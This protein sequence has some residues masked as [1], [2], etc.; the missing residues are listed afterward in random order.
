MTTH[1]V[2]RV[3][4]LGEHKQRLVENVG[5]ESWVY[6][7]IPVKGKVEHNG[8]KLDVY[9]FEWAKIPPHIQ[10]HM[11]RSRAAAQGVP[12]AD[13]HRFLQTHPSA[14]PCADVALE[15]EYADG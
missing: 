8:R 2:T 13:A 5:E 7:G 9:L 4:P 11:I 1:A 6:D 14:I 12:V 15:R 3:R 10:Q